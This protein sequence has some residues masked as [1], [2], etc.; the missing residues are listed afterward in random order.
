MRAFL[1]DGYG[2]IADHVKLADVADPVARFDEVVIEIQAASLNPID[3]KIVRG[4]LKRVS[5]YMLPRCEVSR[6]AAQP[7]GPVLPASWIAHGNES[8]T[9]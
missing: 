9:P 5:K 3:F 1:L 4:D 8:L 6:A 2:A 7:D